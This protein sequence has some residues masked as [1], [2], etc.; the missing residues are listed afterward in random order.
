MKKYEKCY[1][2]YATETYFEIA[3]K[4]IESVRK[5]SSLPIYLYLLN[6][7]LK[8]DIENVTTLR[9]DCDITIDEN[10][11]EVFSNNNFYINRRNKNMYNVLIQRPYI[12]KHCLE[13]YSN[14]VCYIDCDSISTPYVDTIFDYFNVD[15]TYPYFTQGV[16]DYLNFYE[17]GGLPENE[18]QTN[19]VEYNLCQLL[20]T[21][22]KNRNFYRQTGYFVSKIVK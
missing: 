3:K 15:S 16:Y 9:W 22:Q 13:N 8:L 4:S 6:S 1:V 19:T 2:Y 17:R 12:V 10:M 20:N 21:D 18:E 14:M 7:D 5:Y 11:Y